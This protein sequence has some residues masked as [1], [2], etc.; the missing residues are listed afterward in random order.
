MRTLAVSPDAKRPERMI[1]DLNRSLNQYNYIGLNNLV[2]LEAKSITDFTKK[3]I[4]RFFKR[5]SF[6][7]RH[8]LLRIRS[9][10][11]NIKELA[12]LFHFPHYRFN[13]NPR[14]VWQKFKIIPAP[15]SISQDGIVLGDN[16]YG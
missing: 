10:I 16:L 6:T 12:S 4:L 13:K 9:Q 7:F 2:Y 15:D 14:I 8:M 5:P 3:F 1:N 11:L